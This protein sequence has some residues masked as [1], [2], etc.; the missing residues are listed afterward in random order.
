MILNLSQ[1]FHV[2][3]YCYQQILEQFNADNKIN[4]TDYISKIFKLLFSMK[5]IHLQDARTS[6]K[7]Y[8]RLNREIEEESS[9]N[10]V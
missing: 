5:S 10:Y 8:I 9:R 3:K 1:D 4:R 6:C 2:E 7:N